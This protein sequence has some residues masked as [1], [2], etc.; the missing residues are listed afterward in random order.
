MERKRMKSHPQFPPVI[1]PKE[2]ISKVVNFL[3]FLDA[4]K[5][6]LYMPS[7]FGFHLDNYFWAK[8]EALE[9]SRESRGNC[10]QSEFGLILLKFRGGKKTERK[11]LTKWNPEFAKNLLRFLTKNSLNLDSF[12][13]RDISATEE[14]FEF[15]PESLTDLYFC[16]CN[17]KLDACR[18]IATRCPNLKQIRFYVYCDRFESAGVRRIFDSC[19][20]L[21]TIDIYSDS[22]DRSRD[23]DCRNCK[24]TSNKFQ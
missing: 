2:L 19:S 20:K 18:K 24:I 10:K 7:F 17:L 15:L 14:E 9:I 16:D 22:V 4:T 3:D 11:I 12:F 5:L 13:L 8:I 1:M 23:T 6:D 21:Q